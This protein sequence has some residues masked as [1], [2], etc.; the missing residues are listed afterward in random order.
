V[1]GSQ[2]I[3]LGALALSIIACLLNGAFWWNTRGT[4]ESVPQQS[5]SWLAGTSQDKFTQIE[6]HLRGLDQAMAEVGYR[7]GERLGAG[8]ERKW[9]YARYQ[10]EKIELALRLALER[11]LKRA[12]SAQPFLKEALPAVTQA[13][14]SKDAER[15]DVALNQF[16]NSCVECHRS[17]NVLY[18]RGFI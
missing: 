8:K 15:L 3:A 12:P 9:D 17:E 14:D 7:Y 13:I 1:N 6:R 10:T 5:A 2:K 16:H 11:H 4:T 18:F